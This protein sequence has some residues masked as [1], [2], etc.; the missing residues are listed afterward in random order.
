MPISNMLSLCHWPAVTVEVQCLHSV[1][2]WNMITQFQIIST[3]ISDIYLQVAGMADQQMNLLLTCKKWLNGNSPRST[4]TFSI[5][6][7]TYIRCQFDGDGK[8]TNFWPNL[9]N[10]FDSSSSFVFDLPLPCFRTATDSLLS[11]RLQIFFTVFIFQFLSGYFA[12]I[13][14]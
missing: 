1:G 4:T 10:V 14:R 5:R 13:F 3:N 11:T 12:I 2:I 8:L 7:C 9:F 6:N